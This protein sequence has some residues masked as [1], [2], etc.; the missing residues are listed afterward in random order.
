[1]EALLRTETRV[2]LVFEYVSRPD[3]TWVAVCGMPEALAA[4]ASYLEARERLRLLMI[5][6]MGNGAVRQATLVE[7]VPFGA[8]DEDMAY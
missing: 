3:G 1:M 7:D 5:E 4:G 2:H 8:M 6:R